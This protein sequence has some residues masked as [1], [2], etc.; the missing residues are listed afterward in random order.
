MTAMNEERGEP[1]L[2]YMDIEVDGVMERRRFSVQ[3]RG[4]NLYGVSIFA[5]RIPE[6]YDGERLLE[7]IDRPPIIVKAKTR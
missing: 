5:S 4:T 7:F 6:T 2:G 3:S 1:P